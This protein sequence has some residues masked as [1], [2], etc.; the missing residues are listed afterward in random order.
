[1]SN[2]IGFG[3][4]TSGP[5]IDGVDIAV[6]A[7][8][9]ASAAGAGAA[10][11]GGCCAHAV[12]VAPSCHA[13]AIRQAAPT[14]RPLDKQSFIGFFLVNCRD[15]GRRHPVAVNRARDIMR[16]RSYV[17]PVDTK[18]IPCCRPQSET[19]LAKKPQVA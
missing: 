3:L 19:A 16:P 10:G 8:A 13:A 14:R 15:A 9:A 5:A 2:F 6:E 18:P 17:R 4:A 1:M 11:G 7:G 12:G